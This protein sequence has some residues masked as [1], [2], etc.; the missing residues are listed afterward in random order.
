MLNGNDL[1]A[2]N[3][4]KQISISAFH[5]DIDQ[6]N[7]V[8]NGLK[9]QP[10]ITINLPRTDGSLSSFYVTQ[11]HVLAPELAVKYPNLKT[12]KIQQVGDKEVHGR[13]ELV[14]DRLTAMINTPYTQE[15]LTPSDVSG[16][17]RYTVQHKG[18]APQG[19]FS[20]GTKMSQQSNNLGMK[21]PTISQYRT[22]PNTLRKLRVAIATTV[23]YSDNFCGTKSTVLA[24]IA[25]AINRIN[26]VYES[27]LAI[28]LELVSRNEDII[29]LSEDDYD[30]EDANQMIAINRT[31]INAAIGNSN[32]DLG[33]VFSTGGGGLA[34]VGVACSNIA[35]AH[36]VTGRSSPIN[37]PFWIDYVAH[38]MGHQLGAE[39]TFNGT[40]GSC[41]SGNRAA[42]N[43]YEPG[44]GSSIMAYA[45][46]CGGEN[47]QLH[48]DA[49]F[50]SAS[51]DQ[52]NTAL[53]AT[54]CG[55]NVSY[56]SLYSGNSNANA[57][58][59]NAGADYHIPINTPFMLTAMASDADN[60]TLYY[61]WDGTD[62]GS[63][64]NSSSFGID[65]GSRALFRSNLPQTNN[66]RYFPS[67]AKLLSGSSHK[68]E[69]LPIT[70]RD[71]NFKLKVT[72]NKG[73]LA[74]DTMKLTSYMT[75]NTFKMT[76]Q[77]VSTSFT[78]NQS[79]PITWNVVNTISSP[80][81]CS[82]VDIELLSMNADSSQ[83][84]KL[85]LATGVA[86]DG[87]ASVTLPNV[88]SSISRFLIKC[89]D[90]VFFTINDSDFSIA[91]NGNSSPA[92]NSDFK[93]GVDGGLP[94]TTFVSTASTCVATESPKSGGGGGVIA[95]WLLS[96]LAGLLAV[97]R[98][99]FYN[100]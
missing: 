86:N 76:S 87:S 89:S 96:V 32:Y 66:T 95:I 70:N 79:V 72:D 6:F 19:T 61:Q 33:H 30:N 22:T 45:G 100:L 36:G 80:I 38:E 73:G 52:I 81:S 28:T 49:S 62:K 1:S 40:T 29:F 20:C 5:L 91:A 23:E 48:S 67:L 94:A 83:F 56:S 14:D 57:P 26:E 24:E 43:A 34:D 51:I 21:L 82:T 7:T 92:S 63:A 9:T 55:T 15:L 41:G 39:H 84:G 35:K 97:T 65:D 98:R 85:T 77:S 47:L 64:T 99:R 2:K 13:M 58:I 10:S 42:S 60:D 68:G 17:Q 54:S 16:F 44:S 90:N 11:T 12:F 59:A 69:V 37:D 46:I 75:S 78:A 25:I 27:E 53:S 88:S 93:T 31:V 50:H 4:Q 18:V 8:L 3:T 74:N 71:I